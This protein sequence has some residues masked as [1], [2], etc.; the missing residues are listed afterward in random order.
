MGL[1]VCFGVLANEA[2]SNSPVELRA[3]PQGQRGGWYECDVCPSKPGGS[4]YILKI[5]GQEFDWFAEL[6]PRYVWL[7]PNDQGGCGCKDC[8]PWGGNG[9][10]KIS[11]RLAELARQKIPGV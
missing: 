7:W 10:L 4:E 11:R 1:D 2:Y 5:L 6:H 9:F 8:R 3:D